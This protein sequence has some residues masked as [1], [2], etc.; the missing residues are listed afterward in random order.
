MC[1]CS[2]NSSIKSLRNPKDFFLLV[3]KVLAF[4]QILLAALMNYIILQYY[5][6]HDIYILTSMPLEKHLQYIS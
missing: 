5:V 3:R 4:K 1:F 2:Y 6:Y